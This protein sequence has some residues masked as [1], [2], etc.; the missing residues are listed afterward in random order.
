VPPW[1][2]RIPEIGIRGDEHEFLAFDR[3]RA[4]E[5]DGRIASATS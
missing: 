2:R 4:G 1:L 3:E 5:V